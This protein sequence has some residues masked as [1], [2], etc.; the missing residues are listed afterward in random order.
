[1]I[2]SENIDKIIANKDSLNPK[3]AEL[4]CIPKH[5]KE[6]LMNDLY[7]VGVS[8]AVGYLPLKTL[9]E[10]C[11]ERVMDTIIFAKENELSFLQFSYPENCTI[12]SGALYFYHED[13]LKNILMENKNV[14]SKA[15]VPYRD[16]SSFIRHIAMKTVSH[17]MYPEAYIVIMKVFNDNRLRQAV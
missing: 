16:N 6:E 17:S 2:L 14:L 12:C 13:M 11:G 7:N 8:K 10:I 4:R 15:G 3:V 5:S 1:M 9:T